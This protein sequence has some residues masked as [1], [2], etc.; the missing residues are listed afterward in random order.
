[1][2]SLHELTAMPALKDFSVIGISV[3]VPTISERFCIA[4]V[5]ERGFG[6]LL[7]FLPMTLPAFLPSFLVLVRRVVCTLQSFR[8]MQ[9]IFL[10]V[11]VSGCYFHA[12]SD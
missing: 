6:F 3:G 4:R 9:A 2:R 1:M 10:D 7:G 5:V 8:T 12:L 11:S